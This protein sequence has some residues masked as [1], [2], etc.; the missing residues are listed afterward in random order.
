MNSSYSPDGHCQ[1]D[2]LSNLW[3]DER[4]LHHDGGRRGVRTGQATLRQAGEVVEVTAAAGEVERRAHVQFRVK[5]P[6]GVCH[7]T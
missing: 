7:V 4:L 2:C 5:S 6:S 3:C 1:V